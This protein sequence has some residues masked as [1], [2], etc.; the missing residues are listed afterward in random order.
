MR[1]STFI[2]A[3][4]VAALLG[5]CSSHAAVDV[6]PLDA[7]AHAFQWS[8]WGGDAGGSRFAPLTQITPAN[9]AALKPAWT[10]HTGALAKG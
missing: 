10:F 4:A 1:G 2:L 9:V 8:A 6:P 7:A 3:A 5:G